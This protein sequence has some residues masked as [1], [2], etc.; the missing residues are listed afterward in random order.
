[1]T[2]LTIGTRASRLALWQTRH[3]AD[4]LVAAWPGLECR[5]EHFSTAGDRII[6]RPL[7]EI[8][9]KG[10]FTAE[11]EMALR[12]GAI[13]LAVHSLKDLPV[14]DAPGLALGAIV[15][16]ADVRDALVTSDN[17]ELAALPQGA[18]VGTSSLR[19]QAQLLADQPGLDIRSIRGNVE[20]RVNKVLSGEYDAAV[21]AVAGM[22]RL[23]LDDRIGQILPLAIML[24]APGQGA[25]A[26]QCRV[27]D[28][29]TGRLL[30]SIE[31]VGVRTCITAE[32][33]FLRALGGGC[34]T[35]VAAYVQMDGDSLC[36]EG[37]VAATD[38]RRII[39]LQARGVDPLA[40][41][42]ELARRAI[43][44]GAREILDNAE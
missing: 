25:L 20:T 37:L 30:A 31:S 38:V 21:L 40:L 32:R 24:P 39:R 16:R 6:D 42:E 35:P 4:L 14:E 29:E 26:V 3:I 8:G 1:M 33:V 9:G 19:R 18:I 27:D 43:E 36:L 2:K 5:I 28:E 41:G 44:Q 17:R 7:P 23:G 10:L 34:A 13:D 12:D 11:L 22:T 15:G